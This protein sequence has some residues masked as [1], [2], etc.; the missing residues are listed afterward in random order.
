MAKKE[1]AIKTNAA[2]LLDRAKVPYRI[3]PYEVDENDLAAQHVAD[4]LGEDI[5]QVFKTLVLHG[6]PAGQKGQGAGANKGTYFVCVVPGNCEVDL[7][8]AAAAAGMKKADLIPMK[9]LLPL[10]GYIRGGCSPI[11]MKKPFPTFFHSTALDFDHI[12]VSAGIRG[13]QLEMS[14]ADLIKFVGAEVADL[15]KESEE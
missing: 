3:I 4:S 8:K 14:P 13:A 2:R 1:Q 5:R 12:Y 9:E 10:T 11:G 7:K 6:E 15:V